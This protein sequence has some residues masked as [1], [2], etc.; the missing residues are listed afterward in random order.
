M[1]MNCLYSATTWEVPAFIMI[2]GRFFLDEEHCVSLR[3]LLGKYV[4]RLVIALAVWSVIYQLFALIR[5][6]LIGAKYLNFFGIIYECIVG[7]YHLWYIYMQIGLYLLT[8]FLRKIAENKR[9]S[10]YYLVLFLIFSI[11]DSYGRALPGF[12]GAISTVLEKAEVHL[13]LGY[14]GYYLM[15][16]YLHKYELPSK[17]E[18]LLYSAGV[19]MIIF[20]CV[21]T[22]VYSRYIGKPS[23]WFVQY[24]MPSTIIEAAAVYTLFVKR[25]SRIQFSKEVSNFFGRMTELS[26]GT[27]LIHALIQKFVL[28]T[29]ITP[30]TN[31]VIMVPALTLIIFLSSV[32][33]TSIIRRIPRIGELIT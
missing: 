7:E 32:G 18:K 29:G 8:P 5:S 26:F 20:S 17:I 2:S 21:S 16:Y 14:A 1:I 3:D 27:Y 31:P 30:I 10:E 28:M 13:V 4:K 23:D 33:A 15:G 24:L 22:T 19:L 9:L 6:F 25:V 11:L 12:G